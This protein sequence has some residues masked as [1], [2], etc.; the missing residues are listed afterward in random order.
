[1]GGL[2]I[3][4]D[5][6][7]AIPRRVAL[8]LGVDVACPEHQGADNPF[9]TDGRAPVGRAARPCRLGLQKHRGALHDDAQARRLVDPLVH[10]LAHCPGRAGRI[11]PR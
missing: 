7:G 5:R 6:R 2:R 8:A 3:I 9:G 1:M 4:K 10:A 11:D